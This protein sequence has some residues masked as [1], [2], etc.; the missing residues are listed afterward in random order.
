MTAEAVLRRVV[1]ALEQSGIPFMLTGSFA[2]A[3]HGVPRATQDIDLVIDPTP[4]QLVSLIRALPPSEYY[5]D[6]SAALEALRHRGQ[7]NVIDLDSGWKIDLIFRKSRPFSEEEFARRVLV[8]FQASSV[9]VVTVED[10]I[11]A[12]LEWARI[13][14]SSRQIDDVTALLGVRGPDL[15][16]EYLTRWIHQLGLQQ[17]W[18]VASQAA[19][20]DQE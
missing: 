8:P 9:S 3:Y 4:E 10:L 7:F 16:L 17:E 15:D 5:A 20:G 11:V 12:K 13:G 18:R 1:A 19:G 6:E 14:S 2:S